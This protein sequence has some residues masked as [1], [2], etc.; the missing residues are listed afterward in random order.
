M[1]KDEYDLIIEALTAVRVI[2]HQCGDAHPAA[3]RIGEV[4]DR[5]EAGAAR[6]AQGATQQSNALAL[7]IADLLRETYGREFHPPDAAGI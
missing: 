5:L 2:R 6:L 1:I 7:R 3:E 4:A